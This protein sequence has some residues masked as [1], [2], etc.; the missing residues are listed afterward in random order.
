MAL[1]VAEELEMSPDLVSI[2]E[3]DS[4][5]TP[6]D[7]GCFG[8]RVT[9]VCGAAARGTAAALKARLVELAALV[10]QRP[11][12]E[13]RAHDGRVEATAEPTEY[14]SYG[15]VVMAAK[16]RLSEDAFV[17]Y[18]HR[19]GSN[20]GAY[21]VQ[22]AE[23]SVDCATGLTTVTDFLAVGD[24]GQ[25]INRL[26][27]EGQFVG[28]VQMG[29][30]SALCE[31]VRLDERGRPLAG[32]FKTYHIVNAPDM[33]SVRVLLV[34]HEGDD[35]PFGAKSVGE[36]AVVPTAAAVVNAI[37][38]ALGTTLADLPVTPEKIVAALA[39]RQ[40]S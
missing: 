1:I 25:A 23:V 24:V 2:T 40:G 26:M 22:F 19:A 14:L 20:P 6:Y 37:N 15:A 29:I 33:P 27:V 3:A 28:A 21:S 4:D 17:H 9:Y 12:H 11:A 16:T 36:I 18:T 34:E 39:Q 7:F 13:L 31:E 35:G 8:S 10:M 5:T 32:G 38:Q 30:G